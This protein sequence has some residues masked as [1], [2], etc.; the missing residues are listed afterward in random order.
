M[1]EI[2]LYSCYS[3]LTKLLPFVDAQRIAIWGWSYGGFAAALAL[4]KDTAH[5]FRCAASVAPVTD[6]QLYDSIYTER[7][8]GLPGADDNA[9]GYAATRVSALA[10][11]FRNR[12]FF[13]VHGTFDD[14][15]HYQQSMLLARSLELH[16]VLFRQMVSSVTIANGTLGLSI[17]NLQSYP[18][19]G[20]SLASVQRHLY[21]TL[22]QYFDECFST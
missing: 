8:M 20:H 16:D 10:D 14:N 1:F 6:F 3:K 21:H 7:F 18:D 12:T 9:V 17:L 2:P 4:A 15:V 5:V 13:L 22:G 19:E 11:Q